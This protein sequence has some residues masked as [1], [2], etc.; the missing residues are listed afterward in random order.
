MFLASLLAALLSMVN[1]ISTLEVESTTRLRVKNSTGVQLFLTTFC[2]SGII[3]RINLHRSQ[4][5]VLSLLFPRQD[6]S[7]QNRLSFTV[8][9]IQGINTLHPKK[10]LA[11]RKMLNR[12]VTRVRFQL[13]SIK[14]KKPHLFF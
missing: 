8:L 5:V 2:T 1:T 3:F 11:S 7:N 6:G 12:D 14:K 10:D 13:Y 9:F 4:L